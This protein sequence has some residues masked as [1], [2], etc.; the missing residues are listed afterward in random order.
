MARLA[1]P[2][3]NQ[4]VRLNLLKPRVPVR[5]VQSQDFQLRRNIAEGYYAGYI[6]NGILMNIQ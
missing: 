6:T 3:A 5:S 4:F 2:T 1:S